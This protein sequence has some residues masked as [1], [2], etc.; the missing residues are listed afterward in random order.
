MALQAVDSLSSGDLATKLSASLPGGAFC[1]PVSIQ[2]AL[3]LVAAGAAGETLAQLQSVLNW[4]TTPTWQ[5]DLAK[6][7]EGLGAAVAAGEPLLAV[8]NRVYTKVPVRPEYVRAVQACFGASIEPLL[9]AS[10][11]NGFVSQ[12]TRGMI[13]ELVTDQTVAASVLV[14]VNALY[15]KGKWKARFEVDQTRAAPHTPPLGNQCAT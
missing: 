2:L 6:L 7:L 8:A 4:P 13:P 15:F 12:E 5:Q 3:A 9:S 1:A 14:A 10:Q 11:I